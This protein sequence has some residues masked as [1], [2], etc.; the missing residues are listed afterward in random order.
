MTPVFASWHR[1]RDNQRVPTE[2]QPAQAPSRR[3]RATAADAALVAAVD[4]ARSAAED[5]AEPGSVGEHLGA[6][7]E[8]ERVVT[9]TFACTSLAYR[10]W[11]W[12]VTIA[13]AP[14]SRTVTVSE[15]HLLPG[16]DS[17][18]APTWLPWADRLAPGDLSP[19]DVLPK[20][21]DDPLL[22]QGFEA[23][24]DE[25]VDAV[26][27][28]EL[29][30][31]RPRVLSLAGRDEA[32]Q[33]WYDG[34]HGPRDPH[35]EQAPAKC[36]TCGYFVPMAGALRQV[37]GVCANEWS[38][39]DGKVV[40]LDHGC[41]AHSELDVERRPEPLDEPVLDEM[42]YEPVEVERAER[43]ADQPA[44][45]TQDAATEGTEAPTEA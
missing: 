28:W 12:A 30:L 43:A 15:V 45:P 19:G 26:A 35:A 31:G 22:E 14:R 24:G 41:G 5:V 37:F 2:T 20:R 21:V 32:A 33:R 9:H 1:V 42:G 16:D 44:A 40:S 25:D 36:T 7:S 8:G 3:P 23:T 38:P 34:E 6:A 29:G 13:R 10:G 17:V 27:L 39:S 18:V 11:R 4:V